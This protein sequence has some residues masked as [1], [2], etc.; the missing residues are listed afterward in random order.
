LYGRYEIDAVSLV[1]LFVRQTTYSCVK[2]RIRASYDVFVRHT[3]YSCVIRR[4]GRRRRVRCLVFI[5]YFSQKSPRI[6]GS[7]A[8]RDLQL[9]VSYA[10]SPPCKCV[11]YLMN[12]HA[13]YLFACVGM[14]RG[15]MGVRNEDLF[16]QRESHKNRVKI[17][18]NRVNK[19]H[20][21]YL[22]T[23]SSDKKSSTQ[24]GP[25]STETQPLFS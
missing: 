10:S 23:S 7:F 1:S 12:L 17:G 18:E 22:L 20:T 4:T 11:V 5:G 25:F 2:R 3:T 13:I 16:C 19:F 21:H 24:I 8:E 14:Y 15:W 6:S 9:E